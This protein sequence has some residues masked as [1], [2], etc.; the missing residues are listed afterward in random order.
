MDSVVHFEIPADDVQRAEKFYAS[1]FGW[2][3]MSAPGMGYTL[4]TTGPTED[5]MPQKPGFINGGMMKKTDKIKSPVIIIYVDD[6]HKSIDKIKK[7]GGTIV[8]E[9]FTVGDIGISAY[10][11]DS[12]GNL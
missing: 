11:K 6:V 8:M 5:R 3:L 2:D 7:A 9:P 10:F 12:E 4:I 1:C